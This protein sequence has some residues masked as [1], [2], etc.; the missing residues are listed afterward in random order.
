[1]VKLPDLSFEKSAGG[2]VAG[3]DEA[4]RGP[5]AGP[6]V[7]GAVILNYNKIPEGIND[8]KKIPYAKRKILYEKICEHSC[9]G[10]G[11][12]TVE[13]IDRLN[14]LQATLLA[15]H[16]AIENLG[17]TNINLVLI[18]GNKAPKMDFPTKTIIGGDALCLSIAAASIIA[19][20]TRDRIMQDLSHE[21]PEYGW[22]SNFGYGTQKHQEALAKHGITRHH[23]SSYKPIRK[24]LGCL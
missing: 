19:K 5:W 12:S 21:Y 11:I 24:L 8:S 18:D 2:I 13:E 17:N 22:E 14:I 4:G 6:V 15:M 16:R 23:R 3:V 9:I 10:V 20:T 1:M 7:A